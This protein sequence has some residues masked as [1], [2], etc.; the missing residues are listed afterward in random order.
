MDTTALE[1]SLG[2]S[3]LVLCLF[4]SRRLFSSLGNVSLLELAILSY[5]LY[6][7]IT[8]WIAW[9]YAGGSLPSEEPQLLQDTY[10]T[11]AL[12]VLGMSC[13]WWA[14][15]PQIATR[16]GS[17]RSRSTAL[18]HLIPDLKR[19]PQSAILIA[20]IAVLA[21]RVILAFQ[22][23][24]L[25]SGTV[26]EERVLAIPYYLAALSSL[27]EAISSGC[28]LWASTAFNHE[29]GRQRR[30]LALIILSTEFV[31]SFIRGRRWL[32]T[33]FVFVWLGRI[34]TGQ[35]FKLK[36]TVLAVA[37]GVVLVS[38]IFPY[39]LAVRNVYSDSPSAVDAL[40]TAVIQAYYTGDS[41]EHRYTENMSTRPLVSR[42]ITRILDSQENRDPMMG[43][44]LISTFVWAIPTV[45]YS[46][47]RERPQTEA[48]IQQ[49]YGIPVLDASI[50]WP[51]VGVSDF[52]LMGG[53]LSG[54]CVGLFLILAQ[55]IVLSV[56]QRQ[57]L[58][59][60]LICGLLLN[61]ILQAEI[62]PTSYW[63]F[64]RDSMILIAATSGVTLVCRSPSLR[65]VHLSAERRAVT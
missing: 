27:T 24:I 17:T 45:V 64:F 12:H 59:T 47:K 20:Y 8:P 26:V 57:P 13:L 18:Q 62:N 60:L 61:L 52:G 46:D 2:T 51:A 22:Y 34:I 16:N 63:L 35:K 14:S 42:F 3:L 48:L 11:I 43:D 30:W 37:G 15:A 32:L 4:L 28:L 55:I 39:F 33:W 5:G 44:A 56:R 21:V 40:K 31:W 25:F 36:Q 41:V 49:Y 58:S 53:L 6:F 23:G 29:N 7:G 38:V 19:I 1:L 9:L 10:L 50:S 54:L 65:A